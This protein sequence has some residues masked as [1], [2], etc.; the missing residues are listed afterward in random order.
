[1]DIWEQ[2]F[3]LVDDCLRA[4]VFGDYIFR[5]NPPVDSAWLAIGDMC[6]ADAVVSWNQLFG[7][8]SQETHWSKL[9]KQIKIPEGGKLRPFGRDMILEYLSITDEEWIRYHKE[10]VDMRNVRIAHLNLSQSVDSIPNLNK[11]MWCSYLYRN[12]LTEALHLGN[13]IGL[14]ISVSEQRAKDVTEIFKNKIHNAYNG[15]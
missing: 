12:W 1:M 2:H 8:R 4:C 6:Y 5:Q 15:I 7:Q 14:N 11:A 13:R 3:G 9:T 10:M